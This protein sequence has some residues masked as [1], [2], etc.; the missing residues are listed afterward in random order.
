[1]AFKKGETVFGYQ[2]WS[3]GGGGV[4]AFLAT[5]SGLPNRPLGP[6][7]HDSSYRFQSSHDHGFP[8]L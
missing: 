8:S 1:M 5:K 6:L 7:W 4:V 2:N 3:G